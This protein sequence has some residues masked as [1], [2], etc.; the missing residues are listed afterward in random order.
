MA[1]ERIQV[2]GNIGSAEILKSSAGMPYFQMSV[3]VDRG[4]GDAKQVVWYKV[5][6]FGAM[7]KNEAA[8]ANY[9]VGRQVLVEGRPQVEGYLKKDGTV[10]LD[11]VIIAISM[12]E[13]LGH[14]HPRAPR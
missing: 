3:A 2:V 1:Y 4:Q 13:L 14:K 10:G 9:V 6:L 12:P 11:N 5:L 7:V 8:L